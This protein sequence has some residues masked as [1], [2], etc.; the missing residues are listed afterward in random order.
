MGQRIR[1]GNPDPDSGG[2][3]CHKKGKIKLFMFEEF[4]VMLEASPGPESTL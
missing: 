1:I 2:L 4:S 3:N